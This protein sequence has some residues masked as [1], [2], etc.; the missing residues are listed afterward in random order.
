MRVVLVCSPK[1]RVLPAHCATAAA[2]LS[3]TRMKAP[4]ALACYSHCRAAPV[5]LPAHRETLAPTRSRMRTDS[6]RWPRARAILAA[7]STNHHQCRSPNDSQ[8]PTAPLHSPM[9]RANPP[10][11]PSCCCYLEAARH[12]AGRTRV[13]CL[14]LSEPTADPRALSLPPAPAPV[15]RPTSKEKRPR[16]IELRIENCGV[17]ISWRLPWIRSPGRT[18][19]G[20]RESV[21]A[22][23]FVGH[24][25]PTLEVIAIGPPGE[26]AE[27]SRL[28]REG[29]A[30]AS[31]ISD[32]SEFQNIS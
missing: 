28:S 10:P 12:P 26:N 24:W 25:S 16:S 2:P 9:N 5:C 3:R 21:S 1:S 15:A 23:A 11:R 29:K 14:V 20:P 30:E 18:I 6:A 8:S 32:P 17:R 19:S 4:N 7:V 22:P 31:R 27:S 13:E